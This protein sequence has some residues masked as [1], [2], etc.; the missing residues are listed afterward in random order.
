MPRV[1]LLLVVFACLAGLTLDSAGTASASGGIAFDSSPGIEAPPA[2]LGPYA[3][4]P[5]GLDSQPFG[6]VDGVGGLSFAPALSH[7][8]IGQGWATLL[9]GR[10]HDGS[11]A[12]DDGHASDR[13][14][15]VLFL[16]RA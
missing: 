11:V 14:L 1:R 9:W 5:F 16:R 6:P 4:T 8:R 3:M 7:V 13:D 10:L 2:T 15:G 12:H